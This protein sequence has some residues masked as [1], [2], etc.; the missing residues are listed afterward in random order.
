MPDLKAGKP[1]W[2]TIVREAASLWLRFQA[3]RELDADGKLEDPIWAIDPSVAMLFVA[4]AENKDRPDLLGL[5]DEETLSDFAFLLGAQCRNEARNR[6]IFLYGQEADF[7]SI[8]SSMVRAA[9]GARKGIQSVFPELS[10]THL[11]NG[12]ESFIKLRL[13]R[14]ALSTADAKF[15]LLRNFI[16]E[17]QIA[18]SAS[19]ERAGL[20]PKVNT[21]D[22]EVDKLAQVWFDA[23]KAKKSKRRAAHRSRHRP[24][25]A[26]GGG[27]AP[28]PGA[29]Y[30]PGCRPPAGGDRRTCQA[31]VPRG[32]EDPGN[33]DPSGWGCPARRRPS[34]TAAGRAAFGA[35]QR[36]L[37][38]RTA[39]RTR[40]PG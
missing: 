16:R 2:I 7:Q 37:S 11:S 14:K 6:S 17:T 27:R 24:S 36:D 32:G 10:E 34:R 31:C 33:S 40:S 30:I 35:R 25:A 22:D 23:L 21:E 13:V 19:A 8:Y 39:A 29:A 38:G 5:L 1:S 20:M 9:S 15:T 3:G 18:D 26:S 12:E 4:P 28:R